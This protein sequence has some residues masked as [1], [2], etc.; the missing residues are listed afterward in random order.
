MFYGAYISAEGAQA[1]SRRLEILAN[2]L[3]NVDTTGFKRDLAVVRARHAEE[4]DIGLDFPGSGSI[5]NVGGGV[6]LVETQTDFSMGPLTLTGQPTDMAI[7]GQG[8]F[9][10]RKPDGDYL[11]RAGNFALRPTGELV[12]QEGYA[13]LD[14]DGNPIVID[15]EV[16]PW[17]I[18]SDGAIV[19]GDGGGVLLSLVTP[20]SLGDLVKA[21]E[22][23]FRPLADPLPVPPE[24]RRVAQGYLER[25]G[26]QPT[27]EMMDLI[28]ASRA[29]EAN[30][31]MIR[32]QDQMI[33]S[34][35]GRL[36]RA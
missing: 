7:E 9:R 20:R 31:N 1:Q 2:N 3:A 27:L 15:T 25:S 5:N 22:N 19:Q 23:L 17:T 30:V 10:V 36:L 26:V 6:R 8:F 28:T 29:F 34:L 35:V 32:N 16:G 33:G 11:T 13:V 21:G 18:N 14:S 24:A 12:T 4:I